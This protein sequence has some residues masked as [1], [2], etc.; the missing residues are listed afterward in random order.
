MS[1][2]S[3]S[4]SATSR[5]RTSVRVVSV[6][7]VL[8]GAAACSSGGNDTTA[9][10]GSTA[11]TE[12]ATGDPVDDGSETEGPDDPGTT[13]GPPTTATTAPPPPP[14]PAPPV[15]VGALQSGVEGART[16]ALQER[17]HQLR[18]D[19]GEV[20]GRFGLKTTMAVWAFQAL[21]GL[22]R[23]GIVTLELELRIASAAPAT[24]MRPDLG[25]THTEVDLDRQV[26]TVW[27]D[28]RL[29]LVTHVSSGSG[30]AYCERGRCGDA[31]T[32]LGDHRYQRRI[33]GERRAPLGIL[34]D[35]VYFKGGIAVHGAPSVPVRPASHGCVRIPLHISDDFQGLVA[36]GEA[37]AVFRGGVGPSAVV[38]P[39]AGPAAP[40]PAGDEN[41]G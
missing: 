18:F 6:I 29:E 23:D 9:T 37:I 32:P 5:P 2:S 1:S 24:M 19:P 27:G 3:P 39:P 38:P 22:P 13:V 21:A 36:D 12:T 8:L 26:L 11:T 28:G 17:L 15:E 7:A 33:V 25:P 14:P 20:D 30:V 16:L 4:S 40:A 10:A 34:Y 35:P 41:G 31:V